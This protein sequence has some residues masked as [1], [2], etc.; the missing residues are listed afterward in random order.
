MLV[1]HRREKNSILYELNFGKYRFWILSENT[2]NQNEFIA[3][4]SSGSKALIINEFLINSLCCVLSDQIIWLFS[5]SILQFISFWCFK[6]DKMFW[7]SSFSFVLL[8]I[9]SR[10][11]DPLMK[12]VWWWSIGFWLLICN[13]LILSDFLN[14]L[15]IS[16]CS[17]TL[18]FFLS[19]IF[20]ISYYGFIY[21]LCCIY[22]LV[23]YMN[24]NMITMVETT[25]ILL[26]IFYSAYL[27]LIL[28]LE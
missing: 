27:S 9:S 8:V 7:L 2:Y 28:D 18:C 11:L 1:E 15:F 14:L 24:N 5:Q 12:F 21:I 26:K 23:I 6:I 13:F 19:C 20:D 16:R 25:V 22:Y 10:R 3:Q 17:S 4:F